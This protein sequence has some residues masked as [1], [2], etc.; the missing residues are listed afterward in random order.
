MII[1][2]THKRNRVSITRRIF[3]IFR[4]IFIYLISIAVVLGAIV[5]VSDN[6]P[7]KSLFGYRYYTVLTGSMEPSF[8][9]GDMVIVKLSNAEDIDV[10][11]VITFNPSS[12]SDAYLTHRVVQKYENYENT[13][14]TCFK[15]QGDAN[16]TEDAFLIE[17]TRVIGTVVF[18][19][20]K[21]GYIVRFVQL[22]WYFVLAFLVL[23]CVFF[24]LVGYYFSLNDEPTQDSK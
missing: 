9:V 10:G 16:N 14:M 17:S 13:N 24:K 21:L 19:V 11:D 18:S 3:S 6:S 4:T 5:F 12:D 15:T 2:D 8:S 22:K 7:Q 1:I 23:I 20:P